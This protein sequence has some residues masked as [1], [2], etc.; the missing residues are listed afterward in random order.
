MFTEYMS[1]PYDE[2]VLSVEEQEA[3]ERLGYEF[4]MQME[5]KLEELGLTIIESIGWCITKFSQ[6][7]LNAMPKARRLPNGSYE[8]IK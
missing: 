6:E 7:E 1:L 3:I 2:E 4:Y 5:K 8:V